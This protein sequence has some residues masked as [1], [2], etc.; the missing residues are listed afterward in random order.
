MTAEP[1]RGDWAVVAYFL[2]EGDATRAEIR[3]ATGW[4][5]KKMGGLLAAMI[6]ADL[7]RSKR[8]RVWMTQKG[9]TAARTGR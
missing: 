3:A 6:A 9:L 8:N 2:G 1:L 5:K 7:V 4:N